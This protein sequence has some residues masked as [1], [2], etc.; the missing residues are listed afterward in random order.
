MARDQEWHELND[1]VAQL[2]ARV[3]ALDGLIEDGA[4]PA[5]VESTLSGGIVGRARDTETSAR[6]SVS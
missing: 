5:V 2:A 3:M 1:R 6:V 4:R